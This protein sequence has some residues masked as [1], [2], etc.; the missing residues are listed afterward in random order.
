MNMCGVS[1]QAKGSQAAKVGLIYVI[2]SGIYVLLFNG[3]VK[4]LVSKLGQPPRYQI[5]ADQPVA[6]THKV[7][8]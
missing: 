5:A 3:L 4:K 6:P 8:A 7:Q 1:V 2:V